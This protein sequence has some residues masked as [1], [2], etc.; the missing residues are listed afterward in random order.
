[1]VRINNNATATI[2]K[3]ASIKLRLITSSTLQENTIPIIA[4]APNLE[5]PTTILENPNAAPK[6]F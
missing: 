5:C 4:F 1:M 6:T 2:E 3:L